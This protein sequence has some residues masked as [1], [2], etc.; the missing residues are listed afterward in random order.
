LTIEPWSATFPLTWGAGMPNSEVSLRVLPN[1]FELDRRAGE[2][3]KQGLKVSLPGQ[4]FQLLVLLM[5]HSGEVVTREEIRKILWADSYVKFDGSIYSAINRLRHS[6]DDTP[7]NPRLI[8]TVPG[9]GYRFTAQWNP[10]TTVPALHSGEVV[11]VKPRVAVL[12]FENLSGNVAEEYLADSL[13]DALITTLAKMSSLTVKPRS[14]V[15]AYKHARSTLSATC[16]KLNVEAVVQGAVVRCGN[17]VRVTVQLIRAAT[18]EH[19]WAESYDHKFHDLLAFQANIAGAIAAQVTHKLNPGFR[20]ISLMTRPR[21]PAAYE[22]Y[23]KAHYVFKNFTDE[24]LCKA[25]HYW[26]KAIQEDPDYAKAY[27]GLAESC[28]MLGIT[29]VIPVAE[30]LEQS[31]GAANKALEIDDSLSEAHTSLGCAHMLEWDWASAEREFQRAIELDP[32]LATCNPCHYLEYLMA[33]GRPAEAIAEVERVQEIQPLSNFL[34]VVMGWIY[35]CNQYYDR[36]VR[37]HQKMLA[38]NPNSALTHWCLGMDYSQKRKYRSAIEECRKA[39]LLGGTRNVLSALG[40]AYAMAG[41]KD[42]AHHILKELKGLL[43]ATYAPP[44]AFATIYAGLG[45]KDAAFDW[46]GRAYLVHDAGLIWMKWDPQLDNLR[47]DSRFQK[48]LDDIG[49]Q[50]PVSLN[51]KMAKGA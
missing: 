33:M 31:R 30:A 19:L 35:Y 6:L 47:S 37:Q 13:T 27:A 34:G 3:R 21:R 10:T 7:G 12:P 22:A 48:L 1:G 25:R 20:Q 32:N 29:S 44:Y 16:G 9:Y 14:S 49:L 2:I 43:R 51:N 4:L 45:E 39:R 42:R 46:L 8:E 28:N 18:E 41:E 26:K 24:G 36:A 38:V 17:R 23:L 50:S 11:S 40:Y 5:E 15:M